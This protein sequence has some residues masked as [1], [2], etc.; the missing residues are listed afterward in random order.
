MA[1]GVAGTAFPAGKRTLPVGP[2]LL[3][4]ALAAGLV[5]RVAPAQLNSFPLVDGG[6]FATMALDIR[7]AGFF[8]PYA[9]SYNGEGIP[10]AYPPLGI[11]IL[12][13]IPSDPIVTERW[14]PIV[15]SLA[16]IV[17]AYLLAREL[18]DE[19]RAG[20]AAVIFAAMPVAWA[21]EGGGVTR[22]LAFM[23]LLAT[24]WR[25]VIV[26]R[27]PTIGN[28]AWTG[29]A[30]GLAILAHPAVGPTIVAS[31][32]LLFAFSPSRRRLLAVI[33]SG[34]LAA[35]PVAPWLVLILTR[36]GPSPILSAGGAH[37]TEETLGRLLVA[38]PSYIGALDFVLPLAL[39]GLALAV[40]RRDWLLPAWLVVLIAV[41]GGEG[42]YA[43]IAWALLAATG[44]ATVASALKAVGAQRVG[45]AVAG[46]WIFLASL[47][48]GYQQF[49]ALPPGI[50]QAMVAA[51][52]AVPPGTRFAVVLDDAKLTQ[53]VLDWFPTLSGRI[54]VGT[55][56]G[57]EWTSVARWDQTVA[58]NYRIQRGEI[59]SDADYVF[60]IDRGSATWQP[61]R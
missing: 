32:A 53:P 2:A 44:L 43:A 57:L 36:Y 60:R 4:L 31:V 51:G 34:L 15:W 46:G 59:P 11:Y 10:F 56:M 18:T 45:L 23:L 8:L 16:A 38:G 9:T 21:I 25:V 29:A 1:M 24:L 40:H 58:L 19:R 54:S 20:I 5:L 12:A 3:G 30:A 42:R 7:H 22:A 47:L 6:L 27:Q 48:A 61:A 33:G 26:L 35:V 13:A 50:R 52:R 37:H 17:F 14:L 28:T 39:L 49:Q 55:F 41:P